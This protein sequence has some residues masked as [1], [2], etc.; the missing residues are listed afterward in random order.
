MTP[1]GL[2]GKGRAMTTM[3]FVG[4]ATAAATPL[5][6][7]LSLPAAPP[8]LPQTHTPPI[9]PPPLPDFTFAPLVTSTQQQ[10]DDDALFGLVPRG[11]SV[12]G[13]VRDVDVD[14]DDAG[15]VRDVPVVEAECDVD[16]DVGVDV[17]VGVGVGVGEDEEEGEEGAGRREGEKGLGP[18]LLGQAIADFGRDG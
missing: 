18:G 12:L 14:V 17:D 10:H 13:R 5:S 8:L 2:K 11:N 3:D 6:R 1:R 15:W 7:A 9:S 16:A 4:A